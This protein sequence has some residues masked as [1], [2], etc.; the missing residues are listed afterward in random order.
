MNQV[1]MTLITTNQ[2]ALF[3]GGRVAGDR[4]SMNLDVHDCGTHK[5]YFAACESM[6]FYMCVLFNAVVFKLS[7]LADPGPGCHS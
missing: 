1:S 7:T 3:G 6:C 5:F 2:I 4:S